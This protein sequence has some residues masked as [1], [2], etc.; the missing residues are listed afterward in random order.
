MTSKR[1]SWKKVID[2]RRKE[3]FVGR[4]N[5]LDQFSQN[6]SSD[7][8]SYLLFFVTGEG[9]VGKS[10]L[11][12]QFES[13]SI[14]SDIDA[15]VITCDDDE[16]APVNAMG[17]I[18]EQ[19]AKFDISF[20]D[21]DERY[22][23]YRA[24]R[25]QI[26]SDPK[27]PRG[28]LNLVV[29]GMT[30]FAIKS[31]RRTPGV[32]VFVEYVD[33]KE[34]GLA[35]TEGVNYLIDRISNK[36]ELELLREPERILTPLFI[37]LLNIACEGK[38]LVLM[39]DVFER[40]R[41]ALDPWLSE[42]ID[43]KYGEFYTG[44]TVVISG[45]DMPDQHWTQIPSSICYITL[46]P[47][48]LEETRS[49]LSLRN[50]T[51]KQLVEQIFDDTNGLPVLVELLAGT[52][53]KPGSPLPDISKDAVKR[54]LQWIPEDEQRLV[55]L[56]AAVPRHFNLDILRAVLDDIS[57]N[58]FYWL[59]VQSYVRTNTIHGYF[60]HEKV[61]E[62]MLRHLR[63]MRP[64]DLT[65]AHERMAGFFET[66]QK[67][68][69][70]D[71]KAAYNNEAW[72]DLEIER[73]YHMLCEESKGNVTKALNPFLRAF[74][75]RWRFA[76]EILQACKQATHELGS[77]EAQVSVRVLEK[78]YLA[79]EKNEYE[80]LVNQ[81]EI[82]IRKGDLDV[83]AE[84]ALRKRRGDSFRQMG[85]YAQALADYDRTIALDENYVWAIAHRG[86]TYQ[87]MKNYQQALL[88]FDRAITLDE[89]YIWAIAQRGHTYQLMKNYQQALLDFDRA[90]SLDE[91]YI[92]AIAQRGY[93]YRLMKNYQQALLDFDHAI[94]LDEKD[95]WAINDR[96]LTH[97]A[98]GNYEQALE[99]FNRAITLDEKYIWA[100][101]NR[102]N[103]YRLM[104]DYEHALAD[105]DLAVALDNKSADIMSDR[106][107][108]YRLIGDYEHALE[109]YN[110]AIALDEKY[111]W[112][113]YGRGLTYKAMENYEQALADFNNAIALDEKFKWA[114]ANRGDTY[115]LLG[116]YEQALAD[117]DHAI[118]LDDKYIWVIVN[119]GNTYQLIGDYEDALVDFDRAIALD[120]KNPSRVADRG[121]LYWEMGELE[122]S[123]ADFESAIKMDNDYHRAYE[124]R[125]IILRSLNR[126]ESAIESL[127]HAENPD[128][129]CAVCLAHRGEIFRR[130]GQTQQA[131]I[132]LNKAI[133]LETNNQSYE[134][135]RR[136]AIYHSLGDIDARDKDIAHIMEL[137]SEEGYIFYNKAVVLALKGQYQE[138]INLL[139]KAIKKDASARTYAQY[140]DLFDPLKELPEFLEITK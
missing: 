11:L 13:I 64:S 129:P 124:Y 1:Q 34:A 18:A 137:S 2:E 88:D 42:F 109:D 16:S 5:Y 96:G 102:G 67:E 81:A 140:D 60:Y 123:L 52:N 126:L 27:A 108:T 91:N 14:K 47:F 97:K 139:R 51:N 127:F 135:S 71:G 117:F 63:N 101:A 94:A 106:G 8:P 115:Q 120:E 9:G 58:D 46:E 62:L 7:I 80:E 23:T 25:D 131:L 69:G 17:Y 39:F 22:K 35:L 15:I 45:R 87:L 104:K 53:P 28:A 92:W 85:K 3:N 111:V 43:F 98:M 40:T 61:R 77:H 89:N 48:T 95:I 65:S 75:W 73:I 133:S 130:M 59:S 6:F 24:R 128:S 37:E 50:I 112:A 36:D 33:E 70:L 100:I 56:L 138:A 54:F 55:V 76:G 122:K 66:K 110:H 68:M 21:F 72:R 90:I 84:A 114:F 103:F 82:L 121:N 99:D 78:L 38:K 116:N 29:R 125:S 74:R 31:A 49:Y 132:D 83:A 79:F 4:G 57:S 44:L 12:K 26:E 20:K 41:E 86:Y 32:G 93:T 10:T 119:R 105:F 19:L 136:A 107:N 134:R 118:V 113:V 30:D